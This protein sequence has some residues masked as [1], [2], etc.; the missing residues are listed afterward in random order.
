MDNYPI[1]NFWDS[2]RV[3]FSNS[4]S[5]PDK[6]IINHGMIG[7]DDIKSQNSQIE[8]PIEFK[9]FLFYHLY[10][11]NYI[12]P[13]LFYKTLKYLCKS[14]KLFYKQYNEFIVIIGTSNQYQLNINTIY[15]KI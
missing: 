3:N 7:W 4:E 14:I 1:P 15:L 9:K 12:S 5:I 10:L 2:L 6:N 11:T 8:I 13:D